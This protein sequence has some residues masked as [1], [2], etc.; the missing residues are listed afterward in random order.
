MK[1]SPTGRATGKSTYSAQI[2]VGAVIAA[3]Q[4]NTEG[5]TSELAFATSAAD[6]EKEKEKAKEGRR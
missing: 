1:R 3:T 5:G 4:T 2:P 6:P